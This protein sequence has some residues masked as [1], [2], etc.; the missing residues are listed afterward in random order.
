MKTIAPLS[1]AILRFIGGSQVLST[2]TKDV[3]DEGVEFFISL[4]HPNTQYTFRA[5]TTNIYGFDKSEEVTQASN[6]PG[7][8]H[9]S[10]NSLRAR[11]QDSMT[12]GG[13]K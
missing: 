3:A 6:G 10:S 11:R 2:D 5:V 4:S 8:F 7:K 13:H 9:F 12:G 1:L